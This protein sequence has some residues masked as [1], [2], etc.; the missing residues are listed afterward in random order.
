MST[1]SK[2]PK[3]ANGKRG[4]AY[5]RTM[6]RSVPLLAVILLAGCS[7]DLSAS[8]PATPSRARVEPDAA[9]T[10]QVRP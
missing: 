2:A 9:G 10:R 7:K 3:R 4:G 5:S 8:E 1:K 6:V